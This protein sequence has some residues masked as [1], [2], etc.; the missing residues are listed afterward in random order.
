M[1]PRTE[2]ELFQRGLEL[3]HAGRFFEAHEVLEELWRAAK[4][5]QRLFLQALIHF[6]VGLHHAREGNFAGAERQLRKGLRKLA[7]Y[8]PQ[9][10]G[11]DTR[12]LQGDVHRCLGEVIQR[13][14]PRSTPEIVRIYTESRA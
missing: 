2:S 11:V 10:D 12:R 14:Q 13:R 7:G 9:Y 1:E 4:G 5:P 6:A 8:L 3:Y